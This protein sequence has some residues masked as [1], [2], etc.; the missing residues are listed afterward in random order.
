MAYRSLWAIAA[1]TLAVGA[2]AQP[3]PIRIGA[4]VTVRGRAPFLGVHDNKPL[5]LN[6]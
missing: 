6:V 3:E 4:F 1:L 5:E 2:G